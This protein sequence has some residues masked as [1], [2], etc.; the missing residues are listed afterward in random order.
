MTKELAIK[1]QFSLDFAENIANFQQAM[2]ENLEG[3]DLSAMDLD[4]IKVPTGG[5]TQWI[6]T[7]TD[8]EVQCAHIDGVILF[9][10][11]SRTYYESAYG[12]GQAVPPSCYSNDGRVGIGIPGG[13]CAVCPFNQFGS[14]GSGKGKACRESRNFFTMLPGGNMLPVIISAPPSSLKPTKKYLLR[15][16]G[17]RLTSIVTR[18][19][20]KRIVNGAS[21]HSEIC[22]TKLDVLP[23]DL[24]KQYAM[25]ADAIKPT[26]LRAH[27]TLAQAGP[28]EDSY[29]ATEDYI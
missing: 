13:E 21:A 25:L 5:A 14:K 4:R 27:T 17:T 6:Y 1:D 28:A 2:A 18:F 16:G 3:L 8:G 24:A 9:H 15:L 19:S 7:G 26:L 20:L 23:P 22:C 29:T 12:N 11:V 10:A